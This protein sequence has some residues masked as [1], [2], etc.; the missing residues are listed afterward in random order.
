MV[1]L[2]LLCLPLVAAV[3]TATEVYK[4]VDEDGNVIYSDRPREGAQR[5]EAVE[6]QTVE[7]PP[8]P[9]A[10]REPPPVPQA[11]PYETVAV[12]S[13][14]NDATF[15]DTAGNV[16]VSVQV[17]PPLQGHF[18]HRLV[19]YLD[20]EP[21]AEPGMRT[22]FELTNVDRGS[23]TLRAVVIDREGKEVAAS[24]SSTFHLHR[25]SRLFPGRQGGG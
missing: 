8:L 7:P 17:S 10:R 22:S 3:A 16:S 1:R 13:P 6:V 4:W 15:W 2:L 21:I 18:G 11:R 9:P 19:V 24:P 20:G 5:L 12:T 25:A 23:H 14:E